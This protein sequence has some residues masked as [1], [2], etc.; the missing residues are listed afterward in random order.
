MTTPDDTMLAAVADAVDAPFKLVLLARPVAGA[1]EVLVRVHASGINPLDLK[2][3]AGQAAHAGPPLPAILGIDL[4]G[5]VDAIGPGVAG[6]AVGDRVF[7]MTGGA[8]G[9]PGSLAQFAA[10]D[11]TLLAPMPSGLGM[12]EAASI[13]LTFITAWEGLVDRARDA[14][15]MR[16][17]LRGGAGYMAIQN[18][19]AFGAQ[20][21]T[22]VSA[23]TS[24]SWRLSVP[25]PSIGTNT[26][27]RSMSRRIHRT[28][29]STLSSIRW[30]ARCWTPR[31]GPSAGLVTW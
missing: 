26:P 11:A 30:A 14:K 16:V 29:A 8:S 19:R 5:V 15:D 4:A 27:S 3:R 1:G 31:S 10:I 24:I 20:I 12:R 21:F 9:V 7:G 25:P 17:L 6:F 23:A 13:P 22:T 2:I 28:R 18:A